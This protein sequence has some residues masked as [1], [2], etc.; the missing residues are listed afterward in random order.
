MRKTRKEHRSIIY[1][2]TILT[3][4]ML[5]MYATMN[6]SSVFADKERLVRLGTSKEGTVG[7]ACGVGLSAAIKKHVKG[8]TMESV[9]TPGSTA[10]VKI[11]SKKDLDMAYA[12][13]WTMNDAHKNT[14]PFEKVPIARK[15]YQGWYFLDGGFFVITKAD[16][17]D[18]N[19]LHDLVGKK[20]FPHSSGTGVYDV[21]QA[22]FTKLG[23]WDKMKVRQVGPMEAADALQMGT[24]DAI[25]GYSVQGGL[26]TA[27]WIRNIDA[28]L[29]IKIVIPTPEEQNIIR[30]ISGLKF[31]NSIN[32]WMSPKNQ[33]INPP[34]LWGFGPPYG[35]HPGPDMP[36]DVFYNIYKTWIEKAKSDLAPVNATLK[37]Y[38]EFNI[39]EFQV[40]CIETLKD[41]PVHPGVAKYLKEKGVWKD[42]WII[43]KLD[44]GVN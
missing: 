19:S 37:A 29:S 33:K 6:V 35:F 8:V 25:G 31:G 22:V 39:V 20:I 34:E 10:S 11:F 1:I 26:T 42:Y 21:Y 38:S 3:V 30:Q 23:L 27:A 18:I 41:I 32:Q 4:G 12:S 14:G 43:G 24:V 36:T 5:L 15:P 2:V 28:R 7:Y 17:K 16:R 9:P 44:P 13:T 40:D